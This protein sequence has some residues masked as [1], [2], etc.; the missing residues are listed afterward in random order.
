MTT[1]MPVPDC[2]LCGGQAH[3]H[4]FTKFGYDLVKCLG[5]GLAY[6]GNPPNIEDIANLYADEANHQDDLLDV[7]SAMF[8]RQTRVA[9]THL[10]VL[11]KSAAHGRLLDVGC[12]AG[13]FL[14]QARSA[15]FVCNGVEFSPNSAKF[16]RE[17][18]GFDVHIG[19]IHGLGD[20]PDLFDIITMFDVIEHVPD[21]SAD[22]ATI[23]ARLKP[24]GLFLVSTPNIDGLFPQ[25]SLPIA[26][27]IDYW[28]H[29]E[30]PH[31]LYQ[32]SVKT[33]GAM[34]QKA[35]FIVESDQHINIDLAYSFGNFERLRNSPQMLS[36][37]L[38]F[39][40][41]AKLGPFIK[42]GDW[43]YM[44]ARKPVTG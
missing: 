21:P 3:V 44:M 8:A 23:Y 34:L 28:P 42:R 41:L 24:G 43:F 13:H 16:A 15:G 7:G 38:V 10:S 9:A 30:P 31:H 18:F 14:D 22:M 17:H 39:A 4:I 37:A 29:I 36:Y 6:V 12:S 11:K 19:D 5:C 25:A 35:G 20:K 33:L 26:K 27:L 1:K 32:F 2:N 40:P